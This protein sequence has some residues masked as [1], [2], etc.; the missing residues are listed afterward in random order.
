MSSRGN[1]FFLETSCF[2]ADGYAKLNYR[3][4]CSVE[5]A[6][7][8]N[9]NMSVNLFYLSPAPP[10]NLTK[11]LMEHLLKYDNVQVNRVK[12]AEYIHDTPLEDWYLSGVLTTS[13]WPNIHMSDFLR[14]LTLW[15]YGGVY[16]DLDVVLTK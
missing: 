10:S 15:K 1:I 7:R 13:R 14:L 11:R 16:L 4:A 5:A 3:Q 12:V 2:E 6:A 8:T 9:P